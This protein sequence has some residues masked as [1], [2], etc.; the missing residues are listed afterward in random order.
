MKK[1]IKVASYLRVSTEEQKRHGDSLATQRGHIQKYFDENSNAIHVGEYADEGISAD[2]LK[3]R[4][5]LQRLLVDVK[6]GKIDLIIFTKLDRWFRSVPKYYKI[7]EILEENNVSWKTL[8][9]DY[10]TVTSNGKFTV[11]IMLSVAQ[12]ERDRDSDRIK[13]VFNYKI[14][15]GHAV[16]GAQPFPFMIKEID[17]IKRVVHNPETEAMTYDWLNHLKTHN[18]LRGSCVYINEKYDKAYDYQTI[19]KLAKNTLLCGYYRGVKDYAQ[20]YITKQEFDD[21]QEALK[22]NVK[23]RTTGHIH[24]FSKMIK[25]PC[26][27]QNLIGFTSR[28][29]SR[30]TGKT[31]IKYTL[32]CEN[33]YRPEKIKKPCEFKATI[34]EEKTEEY[35]LENLNKLI[36]NYISSLDIKEEK[37]KAVSVDKQKKKIKEE[38]ERLNTMYQKG[39]IDDEKY[40][41]SYEELENKL[42]SLDTVEPKKDVTKLKKILEIDYIEVYK[43]ANKADKKAFWNSIIKEIHVNDK[44][45][46]TNIIFW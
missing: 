8:L 31:T 22:K 36:E 18:S 42:K 40:D 35:L 11:N 17:G 14:K 7:Q 21:L 33:R 25:C 28:Y 1:K 30:T 27:G 44:R 10:E 41:A 9:E 16:S 20:A 39:R 19:A 15:N 6:E 34:Y 13:D 4:T 43:K 29:K 45:E 46:I 24:L 26:C 32:R 37:K 23:V 3:K 5:E 2:K 12:Q 38:M